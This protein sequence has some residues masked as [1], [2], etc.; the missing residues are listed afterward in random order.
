MAYLYFKREVFWLS[1]S[2]GHLM[3]LDTA[4]VFEGS[5]VTVSIVICTRNRPTLLRKCLEGITQ[6]ERTPDEVIV[7]DNTSGD[8]ETKRCSPGICGSLYD[9]S[10]S[11]A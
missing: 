9:L 8:E 2:T 1:S 3:Q 6:L 4:P 5:G 7:V 11:R 10:Q